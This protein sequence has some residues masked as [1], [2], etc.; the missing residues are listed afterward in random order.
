MVTF[1]IRS[2]LEAI[3]QNILSAIIGY[4][5]ALVISRGPSNAA[6]NTLSGDSY[7]GN[8][9]NR[10]AFGYT[11]LDTFYQYPILQTDVPESGPSNNKSSEAKMYVRDSNGAWFTA[12]PITH[13]SLTVEDNNRN[14]P[15]SK[16]SSKAVSFTLSYSPINLHLPFKRLL[17]AEM[18]Y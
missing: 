10:T 16:N 8:G 18:H 6:I 2:F 14:G 9:L 11:Y 12:L 5:W 4:C 15:L 7:A 3:S 17:K 13:P 1:M